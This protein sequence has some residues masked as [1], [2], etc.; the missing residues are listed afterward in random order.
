MIIKRQ[1]FEPSI[2]GSEMIINSLEET[3]LAIPLK[4]ELT[5]LRNRRLPIIFQVS[6]PELPQELVHVWE[7]RYPTRYPKILHNF[8]WGHSARERDRGIILLIRI[9]KIID[10]FILVTSSL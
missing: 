10:V 8:C 2:N 7:G 5:G 1:W 9:C 3:N 6:L 4:D